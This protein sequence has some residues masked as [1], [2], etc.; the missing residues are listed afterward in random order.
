MACDE[1]GR[2]GGELCCPPHASVR[3]ADTP[4]S[5]QPFAKEAEELREQYVRDMAAYKRN[6]EAQS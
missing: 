1:R 6:A 4:R 5:T 3:G 2:Q